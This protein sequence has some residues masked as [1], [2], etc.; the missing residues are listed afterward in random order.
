MNERRA[1][2][3]HALARS[4]S[5]R[6]PSRPL[7]QDCPEPADLYDAAA[8]RL[9]VEQRLRIVDHLAVCAECASAWRLAAELQPA[10]PAPWKMRFASLPRTVLAI[11]AT[12][13]MATGAVY[14]LS[15]PT[16]QQV[17]PAYRDGSTLEP[18]ESRLERA[19]LPREQFRLRWSAGPAGARYTLR[20]T[21]SSL[22]PVLVETGLAAPEFVVAPSVLQDLASGTRLLWQV[23]MT[24]P[25]GRHVSS[26][27]YAVVLR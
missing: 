5:A 24:L 23:E 21:D 16:Q 1:D 13:V 19:E 3:L 8:G 6:A 7:R 26:P 9:D 15:E 4:F 10:S 27:T 11:A 18:P 17:S 14:F 12:I 20:L 25:D 22:N 2:D